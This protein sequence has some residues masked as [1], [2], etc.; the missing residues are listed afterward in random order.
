MKELP[1][2]GGWLKNR[3][4]KVCKELGQ[5]EAARSNWWLAGFRREMA[6]WAEVMKTMQQWSLQ[7]SCLG[8]ENGKDEMRLAALELDWSKN[9]VFTSSWG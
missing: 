9:W 7:E 6:V 4:I 5:E 3:V 1:I 8:R 2:G